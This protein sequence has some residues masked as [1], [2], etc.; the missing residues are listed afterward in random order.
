MREYDLFKEL[1][2]GVGVV[3]VLVLALAAIVGSPDDKTIT[4]K[5]WATAA[6]ADFIATATGE[7]AGTT[8]TAGYG[9]PYTTTAGATQTLG[10]IDLQS[11][12]GTRLP[13][14]TAKDLVITPLTTLG[15]AADA[16]ATWAAASDTQRTDWATAYGEALAKAP[17]GDPAKVAAGD[18]GPV[19]ELTATLQAE[20]VTG[21]VDGAIQQEGGVFNF[22]Y[23]RTILFL[24]DGQYFPGLAAG[25]HLTGDQWGMMNETGNYPG[26]SWLW[27]FSFWYQ[28]PVIGDLPNADLVVV[29]LMGLLTLALALVSVIPGLRDLPRL[30]PLHRLVWRSYYRQR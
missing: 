16:R 14:D 17:K 30:I 24:G 3:G 2:I 11:M 19:P 13:I 7:L 15:A 6:P 26:Q 8:D 5:T 23:T 20:A 12:S 10:P 1:A 9:P 29:G 4:L 28:L 27:L 25:M 21:G 18:Y 22:D